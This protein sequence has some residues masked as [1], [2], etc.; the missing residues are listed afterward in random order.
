MLS[1]SL[2]AEAL[3]GL[4]YHRPSGENSK[5]PSLA[6]LAPFSLNSG[7][8]TLVHGLHCTV[9]TPT[10][11]TG[12]CSWCLIALWGSLTWVWEGMSGDWRLWASSTSRSWAM[13]TVGVDCSW[14]AR[15]TTP[16]PPPQ[17]HGWV[18]LGF[19]VSRF[20]HFWVGGAWHVLSFPGV[21]SFGAL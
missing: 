2:V 5:I 17:P 6:T 9:G 20:P 3:T 19:E 13:G 4:I 18:R 1:F 8:A 21:W 16:G 12:G 14:V 10:P 15:A 11:C 7:L